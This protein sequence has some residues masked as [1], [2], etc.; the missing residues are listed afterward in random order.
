MA[1]AGARTYNRGLGA[2]PLQRCPGAEPLMRGS[3]RR[4]QQAENVLTVESQ[5][6]EQNFSDS[7]YLQ[8]IQTFRESKI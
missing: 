2:K 5:V 8:L 1:S 3:G 7:G 4:S 6:D